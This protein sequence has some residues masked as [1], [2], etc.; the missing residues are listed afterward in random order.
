LHRPACLV[1]P[2]GVSRTSCNLSSRIWILVFHQR[3]QSVCG[4]VRLAYPLVMGCTLWVLLS[5]IFC[6]S[7]SLLFRSYG[8]LSFYSRSLG[9]YCLST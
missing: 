9:N 1:L 3:T 5:E 4:M 7:H 6:C 8:I 2:P